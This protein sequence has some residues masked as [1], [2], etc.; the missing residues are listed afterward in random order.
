[1]GIVKDTDYQLSL[2]INV[3]TVLLVGIVAA[4]IMITSLRF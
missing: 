2:G 4:S 1:M 3:F